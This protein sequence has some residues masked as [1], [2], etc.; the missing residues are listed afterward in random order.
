MNRYPELP[1]TVG[2]LEEDVLQ[3][4]RAPASVAV[5]PAQIAAAALDPASPAVLW[6]P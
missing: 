3:R 1:A 4:W 6:Q 5:D 2:E